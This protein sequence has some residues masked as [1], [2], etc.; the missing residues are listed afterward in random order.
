MN[1]GSRNIY[2]TTGGSGIAGQD[3]RNMK[4]ENVITWSPQRS[5]HGKE[6]W[7]GASLDCF[8]LSKHGQLGALYSW[9]QAVFLCFFFLILRCRFINY[10]S[11]YC[12][13]AAFLFSYI[14]FHILQLDIIR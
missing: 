4:A 6:H 5:M 11:P 13:C 7:N 14:M 8:D 3:W 2:F 1:L 10:L 9:L 12:C